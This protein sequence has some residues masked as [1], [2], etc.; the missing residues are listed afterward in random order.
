MVIDADIFEIFL[1]YLW[2]YNLWNKTNR[3]FIAFN[4]WDIKIYVCFAKSFEKHLEKFHRKYE[5]NTDCI[6]LAFNC[7]LMIQV[8]HADIL[9]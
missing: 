3:N 7:I 5:Q 8:T 9:I 4:P 1:Y 6:V 2:I